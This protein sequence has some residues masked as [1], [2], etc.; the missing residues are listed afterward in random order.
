MPSVGVV[1]SAE[2][3]DY[4]GWQAA[5]FCWSLRQQNVK[6]VIVVHGGGKLDRHYEAILAED[7][8]YVLRASSYVRGGYL[9]W[10]FIGT[11]IEG[12]RELRGQW[13]YLA[14]FDADFVFCAP[15][16]DALPLTPCAQEYSYLY[17]YDPE[18]P[19]TWERLAGDSWARHLEWGKPRCGVPLVVP[20]SLALEWAERARVLLERMAPETRPPAAK[21]WEWM[22]YPLGWAMTDVFGRVGLLDV[23]AFNCWAGELR[24]PMIHYGHSVPEWRKQVQSGRTAWTPPEA[25]RPITAE[26]FRQLRLAGEFYGWRPVT[27]S[28]CE[29]ELRGTFVCSQ[30]A[31]LARPAR[32]GSGARFSVDVPGGAGRIRAS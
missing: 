26:V 14:F 8:G 11:L 3:N 10:N 13:D 22:M 9:P 1:A 4:M 28:A 32:R 19:D 30:N 21:T 15:L 29:P 5:A 20:S 2:N 23:T 7:V 25:G 17:S 18:P 31:Q 6:P 12:A 24:H 16:A 27:C